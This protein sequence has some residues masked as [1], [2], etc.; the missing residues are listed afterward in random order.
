[1]AAQFPTLSCRPCAGGPDKAGPDGHGEADAAVGRIPI[2]IENAS[3]TRAGVNAAT[4][5][6][7]RIKPSPPNS[8]EPNHPNDSGPSHRIVEPAN[9]SPG[10]APSLM[11]TATNRSST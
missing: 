2:Q 10:R 9:S 5:N 3:A 6:A 7:A 11:N 8:P 1:M 4:T